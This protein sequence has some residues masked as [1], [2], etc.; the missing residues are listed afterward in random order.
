M[1]TTPSDHHR[2]ELAVFLKSRRKQLAP[3]EY[4]VVST[5]KRRTPGL[6]REELAE[7]ADLGPTWY[8]WLEQGRNVRASAR[9]LQ[10]IATVLHLN[11]AER[12]HL[13]ALAGY[14]S[15]EDL[16][17]E[18][19]AV[20]SLHATVRAFMSPA[21]IRNDRYDAL[22]WNPGCG[23]LFDL[24]TADPVIERNF[25][26]RVFSNRWRSIVLPEWESLA[27]HLLADL[28]VAYAYHGDAPPFRSLVAD[29]CVVSPLFAEWWLGYPITDLRELAV[30]VVHATAGELHLR[31]RHFDVTANRGLK[32]MLFVPERDSGT[33]AKLA[34][35]VHGGER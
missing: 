9:T 22:V 35:L 16:P 14:A 15:P 21:L 13:L 33:E 19:I 27:K 25:I 30:V 32:L 10:R 1:P 18:V 20:G 12:H 31:I 29:L 4:G 28:R 17:G 23:A 2:A 11:A 26:W 3:E 5:P 24:S 7:L 8:T 34:A 6:R